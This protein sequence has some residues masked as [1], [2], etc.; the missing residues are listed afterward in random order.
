MDSHFDQ[1]ENTII[2]LCRQF[3]QGIAE[4]RINQEM[5]TVPTHQVLGALNKLLRE[6]RISAFTNQDNILHYKEFS[7]EELDKV[8]QLNNV[9][10]Y[11]YQII[12]SASNKGMWYREIKAKSGNLDQ[13]KITKALKVL[14][15]KKTCEMC[16]RANITKQKNVY[17][18]W[19]AV[20]LL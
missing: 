19:S 14:D 3:P 8:D 17:A 13:T 20:S 1:I 16:Y 11:I 9:E 12:A 15:N 10:K 7:R 18:I 6:F 2:R 5:P 4:D